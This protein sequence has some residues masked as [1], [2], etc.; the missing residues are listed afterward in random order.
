[1]DNRSGIR[2]TLAE[3]ELLKVSG[4]GTSDWMSSGSY[5]CDRTV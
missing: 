1:M 3:G 4:A 5:G 2:W